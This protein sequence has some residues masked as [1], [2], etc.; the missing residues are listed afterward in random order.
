MRN[1]EESKFITPYL[2]DFASIFE[3]ALAHESGDP[4][5]LFAKKSEGRKSLDTVPLIA[6]IAVLKAKTYPSLQLASNF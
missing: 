6:H 3:T 4:G 2:R 5:V 1:S